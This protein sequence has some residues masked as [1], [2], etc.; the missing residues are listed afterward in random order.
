MLAT[1]ITSAMEHGLNR[2]AESMYVAS[3][4]WPA[5]SASDR[6]D[7]GACRL[8]AGVDLHCFEDEE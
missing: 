3:R 2:A 4:S 5:V 7:Y 1:N 8:C 6:S